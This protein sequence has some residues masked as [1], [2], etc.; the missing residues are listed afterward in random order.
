MSG[1]QA[2]GLEAVL[3]EVVRASGAMLLLDVS[4]LEAFEPILGS[5]ESGGVFS[6]HFANFVSSISSFN[7]SAECEKE[8]KSEVLLLIDLTFHNTKLKNR[9]IERIF[10]IAAAQHYRARNLLSEHIK[11]ISETFKR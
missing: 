10:E 2:A 9:E 11:H 7:T 8:E 4:I 5:S 6:A 1:R 3:I